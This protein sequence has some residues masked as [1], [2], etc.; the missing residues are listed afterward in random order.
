MNGSFELKLDLRGTK[1]ELKAM[2][3]VV[4]EYT[5]EKS[6]VNFRDVSLNGEEYINEFSDD[7]IDEIISESNG[8]LEISSV[9][10]PGGYYKHFYGFKDIV[11]FQDMAEVAPNAKFKGKMYES[12]GYNTNALTGILK[13]KILNLEEFYYSYEDELKNYCEDFSD[14]ISSKDFAELFKI[15]PQDLEEMRQGIYRKYISLLS[16]LTESFDCIHYD[17]GYY[18]CLDITYDS[19]LDALKDYCIDSELKEDEFDSVLIKLNELMR[20][21]GIL[22]I[23]DFSEL[24]QIEATKNYKYDP[25]AKEYLNKP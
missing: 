17:N 10:Y 24:A 18:I 20:K 5:T 13:D 8:H 16:I 14:K 15:D 3:G 12:V 19:F 1:E 21:A 23:D 2:V 11:F 6:K 25:V 9:D 4:K 22:D 7:E